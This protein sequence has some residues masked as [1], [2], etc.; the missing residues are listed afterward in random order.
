MHKTPLNFFG[1]P[2]ERLAR[3][4]DA[5]RSGNGVIVVDDEDRENEGDLIFSADH[6]TEAQMSQL[7]RDCSGIVCLCLTTER[8]EQ[9]NLPPICENNS[10]PYGTAFT[11]PIEAAHG[12]TT[13]VSAA[14]RVTTI[15]AATA[16][17]ATPSDLIRPGHVFPLRAHPEGVLGRRGHTEGTVDL[18]RLAGLRPFGVLCE[19]TNTDGS[20]MKMDALVD[21]AR[22]CDLPML[23]IE[24]IAQGRAAVTLD[25][26]G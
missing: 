7:I 21:Y 24:D 1:K 19:L 16:D 23:S 12:V 11:V 14:D 4:L 22:Q 10:S 18:M 2:P 15:R 20:M 13:G 17:G 3:G 9:L 8:V 26:T 5:L 6:L 25:R